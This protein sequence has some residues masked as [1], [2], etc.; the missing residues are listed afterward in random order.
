MVKMVMPPG[1]SSRN[2]DLANVVPPFGPTLDKEPVSLVA[3]R[4]SDRQLVQAWHLKE[5]L[6]LVDRV[7]G[8]DAVVNLADGLYLCYNSFLKETCLNE[9]RFVAGAYRTEAGK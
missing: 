1:R 5:G 7:G 4:L 9:L 6:G 3:V 8:P 2:T